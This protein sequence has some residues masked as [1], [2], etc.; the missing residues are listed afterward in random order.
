M[1]GM[2]ITLVLSNLG[3][4]YSTLRGTRTEGLGYAGTDWRSSEVAAHLRGLGPNSVVYSNLCEG[5]YYLGHVG[6]RR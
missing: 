3:G 6:A 1:T 5:A 2:A 4:S